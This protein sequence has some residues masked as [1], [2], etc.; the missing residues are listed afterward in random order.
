MR[1][2]IAITIESDMPDSGTPTLVLGA[3]GVTIG[4]GVYAPLLEWSGLDEFIEMLHEC[5][6]ERHKFVKE[7]T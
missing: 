1:K 2:K 6:R 3:S 7:D 4:A 5:R